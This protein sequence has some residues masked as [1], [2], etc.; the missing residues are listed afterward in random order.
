[1]SFATCKFSPRLCAVM[2]FNGG[3]KMLLL[4]GQTD[5]LDRP[6]TSLLSCFTIN[7]CLLDRK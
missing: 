2:T 7:F 4:W 6:L 5:S 3:S 1:M